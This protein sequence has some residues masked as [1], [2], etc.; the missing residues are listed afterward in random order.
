MKVLRKIL[1]QSGLIFEIR[2]RFKKDMNK[3]QTAK[4]TWHPEIES[5]RREFPE[6]G[7]TKDK[8]M[9]RRKQEGEKPSLCN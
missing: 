9:K 5:V 3:R 6:K 2:E 7:E 4:V 1:K 8:E